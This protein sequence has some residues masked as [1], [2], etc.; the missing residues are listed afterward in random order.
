[1]ASQTAAIADGVAAALNAAPGGTFSQAF[2]AERKYQPQFTLA[3]LAVL[4]VSVV[5]RGRDLE[6]L[7]R[8]LVRKDVLIDVGLHKH[9]PDD[10]DPA[11]AA[12]NASID[13]YLQLA[14]EIAD[15]FESAKP[16]AAGAPFLRSEHAALW[17]PQRLRE[18]RIFFSL[19]TLT[20]RL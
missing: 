12:G 19:I 18:N 13:P 2:T 9:L 3:D 6:R 17:D 16:A 20:Y 8:A 11:A 14:E 1:M 7:T 4:R 5:P 10:T 15:Y